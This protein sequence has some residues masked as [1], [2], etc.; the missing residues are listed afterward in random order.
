MGDKT[1]RDIMAALE[2]S[3]HTTF[4]RLLHARWIRHV[5]EYTALLLA[6]NFKDMD[7]LRNASY[8]DLISIPESGPEVANSI[9]LL[10]ISE[11]TSAFDFDGFHLEHRPQSRGK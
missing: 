11:F 2:K 6:D 4:S 7:A 10:T 9:L 1:A 8:E 3:K 5:G